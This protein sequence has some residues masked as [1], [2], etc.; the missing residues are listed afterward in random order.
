[1]LV[2][3]ALAYILPVHHFVDIC[4]A[5]QTRRK[6]PASPRILL[7]AVL[8]AGLAELGGGHSG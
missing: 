4:R 2:S 3:F 6:S 1:M 8:A 5:C 7:L